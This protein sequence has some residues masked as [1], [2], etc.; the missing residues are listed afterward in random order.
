LRRT[1]I[2]AACSAVL[3]MLPAAIHPVQA[4]ASHAVSAPHR[5]HHAPLPKRVMYGLAHRAKALHR[6]HP[7]LSPHSIFLR[8]C[9]TWRKA[10]RRPAPAAVVP[11]VRLV[12]RR[13]G[14]DP[15]G[16]LRVARCESNLQRTA[17]NGQYLG[18]FQLGSFARARYLDGAWA[19]SYANALAAARYAKEAGGWGPWTCGYA[20]D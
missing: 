8:L 17:T 7:R 20:Y 2:V 4:Q 6:T 15:D 13:Y 9:K 14:F 18:L 5:V 1:T 16:M 19:D 12:A 10:H 3:A 11:S